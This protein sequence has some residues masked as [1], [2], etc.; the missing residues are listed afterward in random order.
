MKKIDDNLIVRSLSGNADVKELEDLAKAIAA[1]DEAAEDFFE[2]KNIWDAAISPEVADKIDTGESLE[3]LLKKISMRSKTEPAFRDKTRSVFMKIAAGLSIPFMLLSAYLYF[4]RNAYGSMPVAANHEITAMPGSLV[5]TILPDSTEIW[6]NGGS[7]IRYHQDNDSPRTVE[8]DGEAFFKVAKDPKHPFRV[9]TA[10][11]LDIEALGTEF[12]VCSYA[13]DTITS[14]TLTEGSVKVN[15]GDWTYTM[16]P[17]QTVV[18]NSNRKKGALYLG[19][20]DKNISWREGKL[21]FNNEP[22][23]NVYKRIGLIYDVNFDVDVRL[24]NVILYA[25]FEKASLDQMLS[26]IQKST[27]LTYQVMEDGQDGSTK[28]TIMVIAE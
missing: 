17:R 21:A 7:M 27:P 1:S 28:K 20:T 26:L 8:I 5:H 15:G 4:S 6:L 18:Y 11:R 10:S 3:Y 23:K 12:N 9:N 24:S 13:K 22:L 2:T 14:V 19:N 16:S 25:T